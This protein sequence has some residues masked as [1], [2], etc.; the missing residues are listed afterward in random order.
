MLNNNDNFM[1]FLLQNQGLS[2]HSSIEP[3]SPK[4]NNGLKKKVIGEN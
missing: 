3:L 1:N 4:H 2:W